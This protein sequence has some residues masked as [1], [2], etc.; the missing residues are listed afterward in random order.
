MCVLFYIQIHFT[1]YHVELICTKTQVEAT[2]YI[3]ACLLIQMEPM[4][5]ANVNDFR[6]Y[7]CDRLQILWSENLFVEAALPYTGSSNVPAR[8]LVTFFLLS[9]A[10][11][12]C[13]V[14]S[15]ETTHF[16]FIYSKTNWKMHMVLT[17]TS[18]RFLS[19]HLKV[20]AGT[21]VHEI[22]LREARGITFDCT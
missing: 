22:Y 4:L 16:T 7:T 5:A 14:C 20:L 21:S 17:I 12:P 3:Q 1:L 2:K 15:R 6:C 11:Q 13:L 10:L 19:Q 9:V 8:F 18:L